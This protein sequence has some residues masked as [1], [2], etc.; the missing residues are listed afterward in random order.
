MIILSL[1][2]NLPS[3][4]GNRFETLDLATNIL[5]KYMYSIA[6]KSSFYETP[7]Y[8]DQNNPKFINIVISIKSDLKRDLDYLVHTIFFIEKKIGR[9]RNKKNDPRTIDIDIIDYNNQVLD[10]KTKDSKLIKIPH[11]KLTS[12]NFVL[13]PLKEICPDWKHPET[14]MHIDVMVDKLPAVDK[15]S[16]LK[17]ENN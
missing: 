10:F 12:R 11:E 13:L 5:S 16:I 17:V 2:S 4:F 15:K 7:S 1:G 9:R 8:P 6:K 3:N 14:G